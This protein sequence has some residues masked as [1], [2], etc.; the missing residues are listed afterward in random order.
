MGA[1]ATGATSGGGGARVAGARAAGAKARARPGQG[2][3]RGEVGWGRG[4]GGGGAGRWVRGQCDQ[5]V[6]EL[7]S[8]AR[9]RQ[10]GKRAW[11]GRSRGSVVIDSLRSLFCSFSL[12]S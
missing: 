2:R 9:L 8:C 10:A 4:E 11:G 7:A 3:P 6:Q 1:R 12:E 5:E